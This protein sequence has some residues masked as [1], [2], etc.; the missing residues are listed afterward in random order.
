MKRTINIL[1][2]TIDSGIYN[3][4][5][6]ILGQQEGIYYIVSHQY[7]DE[8]YRRTPSFLEREDIRVSHIPGRGVTK[9][10]NN[11]I[12]L[13]DGDI[14]LFA[15]DDVTYAKNNFETLERVF[16]EHPEV[17]V[18]LFKIQ[19]GPGEPPYKRYPE[20]SITYQ[21]APSV[22]TVEMGFR[23][24]KIKEKKIRFD[25]RFG[26]GQPLLIGSDERLFVQDCIDAGLTVR[27][28]PE[29]IVHHPYEN[30]VKKIPKYDKRLIWVTGG[31]DCRLNGPLALVK[32]LLGTLKIV[33]DLIRNKVNPLFY[34][35]HRISAVIYILKTNKGPH[36]S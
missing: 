4:D 29:Y 14:G 26:A 25:E 8:Q 30:T 32:A 12:R 13:A 5:K 17:D 7:T 9:S 15:D 18:A 2:S 28:F 35:Y 19:T 24:P 20:K 31:V 34:F 33:P 27:Y 23:I 11:A 16:E 21:D 6:V 10:R 1:I 22:G 3:L 36:E